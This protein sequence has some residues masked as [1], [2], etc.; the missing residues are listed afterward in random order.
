MNEL[1]ELFSLNFE[2]CLQGLP[3]VVALVGIGLLVGTMTGLF[4][5]GGASLVNPLL[6][7]LLGIG[8]TLVVGSGDGAPLANETRG[9]QDRFV[10]GCRG[11]ALRYAG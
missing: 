11:L 8:E 4:G 7:V 5:V 9:R 3:L 1:S 6:I 2:A 10:P